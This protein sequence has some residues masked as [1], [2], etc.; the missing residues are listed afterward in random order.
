[1][2]S[3]RVRFEFDPGRRRR[4]SRRLLTLRASRNGGR[5]ELVLDLCC[6]TARSASLYY[7][8][9]NPR[10]RVVG[11]DRD[12]TRD[13]VLSHL[14]RSV[15]SRF[16]F[17]QEDINDLSLSSLEQAIK[18]KWPAES[19]SQLTRCHWSPPCETLS[20]A[21]RGRSNYRDDL[22]RP[23]RHRSRMDDAAFEAG[24]TL[25]TRLQRLS[26]QTGW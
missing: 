22:S 5:Q 1:M 3:K 13:W 8:L 23:M 16:L 24:V 17:M 10:A 19:L 18:H 7:L 20:R 6:G 26:P 11:V 21:T 14:P 25:V 4:V 15:H 2:G 9:T 12:K